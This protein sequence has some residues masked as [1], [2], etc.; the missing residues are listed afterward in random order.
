[1]IQSDAERMKKSCDYVVL[2]GSWRIATFSGHWDK[3]QR[4][5]GEAGQEH[6]IE[7]HTDELINEHTQLTQVNK[8]KQLIVQLTRSFLASTI[9]IFVKS[10]PR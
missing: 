1:M 5:N 3:F 9:E 4:P 6:G 2:I 8:E 7:R 10:P